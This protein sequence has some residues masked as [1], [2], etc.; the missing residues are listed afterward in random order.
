MVPLRQNTLGYNLTRLRSV[1]KSGFDGEFE[2]G[3]RSTWYCHTHE[4]THQSI[5][6]Y[7]DGALRHR[8]I[9]KV[10]ETEIIVTI[11]AKRRK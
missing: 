2:F 6:V 11:L 10:L 3:G 9:Y 8:I 5:L 4:D 7:L 1:D